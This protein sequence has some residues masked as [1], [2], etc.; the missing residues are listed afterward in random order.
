MGKKIV[1]IGSNFPYGGASA[2]LL[3][4]LTL[5]LAVQNNIVE[6]IIP[7]G[8]H[9]GSKI[10]VNQSRNGKIESVK[11][12]HLGFIIHP[13]NYFGKFL[14]NI[15][16]LI[17]P[18]FFLLHKTIKNDLDMIIVYNPSSFSMVSYLATKLFLRKELL[19][20]L[21][22]FYEKPNSKL[23]S[24]ALIKWY[25]FYLSI[26]YFVRYADKF[27]VLSSYLKNYLLIRLKTSKDIL[28]MPNLTDPR[29][30]E[31]NNIKPFKSDKI[32]IGYVGTPTKKDGVIDLIKSFNEL[33]KK[34]SNTHLLIIGDLTYGESLIPDLERYAENLGISE[35]VT[36]T[37]L[38]SYNKIPNLLNSCQILALIRPNGISAE[39][40]F[41]TKLGEYFA[42][43]KPVIITSV[44][45]IKK[46][47]IN[48]EQVILVEPENIRSIV[49]GFEKI[50]SD[51]KLA[52]KLCITGYKWMDENL[53][54]INQS[55]KISEFINKIKTKR[56]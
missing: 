49:G 56:D 23:I 52:E 33:N 13:K 32:T 53:N 12:R 47:F 5:A 3:R 8:R 26:K 4:N 15:L 6:I 25:S 44:G 27:I 38:V 39:A 45:D 21:P 30:F 46:Y 35:N 36:F 34:R 54:Y 55:K 42:C 10:D 14:D 2:N 28:L 41:P 16:G 50:I 24:L 11:Y 17:L 43:K 31:I 1:V 7:S 48:E 40:G 37:G 29:K 19:V 51:K 20:I 22:E 9:Y 18:F